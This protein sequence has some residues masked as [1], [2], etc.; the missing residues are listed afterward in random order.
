MTSEISSDPLHLKPTQIPTALAII[1]ADINATKPHLDQVVAQP[2][3]MITSATA[4]PK[5]KINLDEGPQRL[6]EPIVMGEYLLTHTLGHGSFVDAYLAE[7]QSFGN[8]AIKVLR[9]EET[10]I[11]GETSTAGGRYA[12]HMFNDERLVL[13]GLRQTLTGLGFDPDL[14]PQL[15]Q[16][17]K[18]KLGNEPKERA[19]I[20]MSLARGTSLD[21]LI[22]QRKQMSHKEDRVFLSSQLEA[23]LIVRDLTRIIAALHK[24]DRTGGDLQFDNTFVRLPAESQDKD[25]LSRAYISTLLDEGGE[26]NH[27]TMTIDWNATEYKAPA[28]AEKLVYR[29]LQMMTRF[30]WRT[31]TGE[32]LPEK[33]SIK[34]LRDHPAWNDLSSGIQEIVTELLTNTVET[35]KV[36]TAEQLLAKI[37]SAIEPWD[38][39]TSSKII[40][41]FLANIRREYSELKESASDYPDKMLKLRQRLHNALPAISTYDRNMLFN[42]SDNVALIKQLQPENFD[43]VFEKAKIMI[44]GFKFE[45]ALTY[46]SVLENSY[47]TSIE[48]IRLQWLCKEMLAELSTANQVKTMS[49]LDRGH[50]L[51]IF[52]LLNTKKYMEAFRISTAY[53]HKELLN[54]SQIY[55]FIQQEIK[56]RIFVSQNKPREARDVI[57]NMDSLVFDTNIGLGNHYIENLKRDLPDLDEKVAKLEAI[58]LNQAHEIARSTLFHDALQKLSSQHDSSDL[59]IFLQENPGMEWKQKLLNLMNAMA[60]DSRYITAA[61]IGQIAFSYS[62]SKPIEKEDQINQKVDFL[63]VHALSEVALIVCSDTIPD[64]TWTAAVS[65]CSQWVPLFKERPLRAKQLTQLILQGQLN[66]ASHGQHDQNSYLRASAVMNQLTRLESDPHAL[67]AQLNEMSQLITAI[68]AG[69]KA[70]IQPNNE[71][72]GEDGQFVFRLLSALSRHQIKDQQG[73]AIADPQI[74]RLFGKADGKT[75]AEKLDAWVRTIQT[76]YKIPEL[77]ILKLKFRLLIDAISDLQVTLPENFVTALIK[78]EK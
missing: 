41:A 67:M 54:Q 16:S 45:N 77:T 56:I 32:L 74:C 49:A 6:N 64:E 5:I 10:M 29:D 63:I 17:G 4:L 65:Q 57:I 30:L 3:N 9:L 76:K 34:M 39:L 58:E 31:M 7:H 70:E 8:C 66:R 13:L 59:I 26:P 50:V 73:K 72:A 68:A 37:N 40:N 43:V 52:D 12:I 1:S 44:S 14:V 18:A 71:T 60:D 23:L 20:V 46:L 35:G 33:P 53:P 27:K 69:L 62:P 11:R 38:M 51:L 42:E 48:L 21:K 61:Q 78:V 15:L 25:P 19:Y 47:G 28:E 2:E 36:K 22:I 75:P 24:N 55:R